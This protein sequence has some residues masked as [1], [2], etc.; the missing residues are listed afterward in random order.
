MF[1]RRIFFAE[2]WLKKLC[3]SRRP[4]ATRGMVAIVKGAAARWRDG[5]ARETF[6][7]FS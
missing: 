2:K 6:S 4:R 5:A 1:K 7:L 3:V